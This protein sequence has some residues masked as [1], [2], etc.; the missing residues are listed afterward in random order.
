MP[1]VMCTYFSRYCRTSLEIIDSGQSF[2]A[3]TLEMH[4]EFK[5]FSCT[6]RT[7]CPWNSKH[8]VLSFQSFSLRIT[9]L[10]YNLFTPC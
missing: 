1:K 9:L 3:E 2:D 5:Y 4:M 10:I 8:I 6:K 7:I